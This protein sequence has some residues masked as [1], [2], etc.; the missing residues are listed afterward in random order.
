MIRMAEDQSELTSSSAS[1]L[2]KSFSPIELKASTPQGVIKELSDAYDVPEILVRSLFNMNG[3]NNQSN[4]N[5]RKFIIN[6]ESEIIEFI[7]K[8]NV[9]SWK[10]TP[11]NSYYRLLTHKLAEYYNLGHIL[12]N[13]GY[14][15]V[16]FKI[17]TSLVNADD[18]TKKSAAFDDEGN[19][20]PLDF[21]NIKFD[22]MEKLDRIRVSEIFE[23][24]KSHF[25]S[26]LEREQEDELPVSGKN[27]RA[28]KKNGKDEGHQNGSSGYSKNGNGHHLEDDK[29]SGKQRNRVDHGNMDGSNG[30]V[31][32][33][34]DT[35]PRGNRK[36]Y[37]H[38]PLPEYGYYHPF[39]PYNYPYGPPPQM[40]AQP[41]ESTP[42][43]MKSASLSEGQGHSPNPS[44]G[45]PPY[46]YIYAMPTPPEA[47]IAPIPPSQ[48]PAESSPNSASS[49]PLSAS[50]S[51]PPVQMVPSYQY[52]Y[53]PPHPGLYY[54]MGPGSNGGRYS[55]GRNKYSDNNNGYY[56]SSQNGEKKSHKKWS[57]GGDK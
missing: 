1:T 16:L 54:Q 56:R 49:T 33:E 43:N 31:D 8:P 30:F 48:V 24:Y 52:Y 32:G 55:N 26:S 53:P 36:K 44:S 3:R 41:M 45:I 15:M 23:N 4:L 40:I 29:S 38:P 28:P 13:D 11:L 42:V 19:I 35:R 20:K 12:S 2:K 50:A 27:G 25:S 47:P 14:S 17:N 10:M 9:D 39:V 5:D 51:M 46:P 37:Q 7:V 34:S 6:L 18:E 22:P 21:R 57:N